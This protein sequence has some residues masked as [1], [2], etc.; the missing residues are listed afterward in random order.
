MSSR[1]AKP[2]SKPSLTVYGIFHH[3]RWDEWEHMTPATQAEW[4]DTAAFRKRNKLP[5]TGVVRGLIAELKKGKVTTV[6]C[7]SHINDMTK[8]NPFRISPVYQFSKS[9]R[10]S[11]ERNKIVITPIAQ[12]VGDTALYFLSVSLY[13]YRHFCVEN[14]LRGGRE[15][16]RKIFYE[17]IP[18]LTAQWT[19]VEQNNSHL[20]LQATLHAKL[21]AATENWLFGENSGQWASFVDLHHAVSYLRSKAMLEAARRQGFQHIIVGDIHG[22]EIKLLEKRAKFVRVAPINFTG[23]H[24]VQ[25]GSERYRRI[26]EFADS[27]QKIIADHPGGDEVLGTGVNARLFTNM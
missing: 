20:Q 25:Q 15:I 5:V 18:S 9:L 1:K 24:L 11:A 27:L 12:T 6:A 8:D 23:T 16:W 26:K 17:S 21:M 19:V 22:Q 10:L 3:L 14:N 4:K 13:N 7:E 2:L